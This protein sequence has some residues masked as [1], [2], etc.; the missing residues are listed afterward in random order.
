MKEIIDFFTKSDGLILDPFAGV[1]GTMLGATLSGGNRYAIGVELNQEYIEA[2][3]KVCASEEYPIMPII[4]D[5]V[6]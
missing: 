2:Y 5:D 3:K 4:Q 1:G 6:I